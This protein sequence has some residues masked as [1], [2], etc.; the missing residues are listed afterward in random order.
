MSFQFPEF[1]AAPEQSSLTAVQSSLEKTELSMRLT[2]LMGEL[3][4]VISEVRETG[5]S[6]IDRTRALRVE[7]GFDPDDAPTAHLRPLFGT[8]AA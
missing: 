4:D 8:A 1:A 2:S 6:H 3:R 5:S 7:F